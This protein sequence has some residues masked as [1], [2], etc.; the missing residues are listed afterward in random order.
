MRASVKTGAM[1]A[2]FAPSIVG[3]ALAQQPPGAP[4][5]AA[6]APAAPAKPSAPP[7]PDWNT[8]G[9]DQ[10]R[11]A[12]NKGETTLNKD[13]VS[14]LKLL[15]STQTTTPVS[16]VVL[17]TLTTP[18]VSMDVRTPSGR[19][20]L[21]YVLDAFDTLFALDADSGKIVWHKNFP[22]TLKPLRAG[23]WLCPNTTNATPVIDKQRGLVFVLTSDGRLRAVSAGD[24]AERMAATDV[25]APFSRSWSLNL[26]D[27]V[28]YT[29]SGRGCASLLDPKSPISAASTITSGG[30][31]G[32]AA[33]PAEPGSVS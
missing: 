33:T 21:V 8:W 20:N 18:L 4:P 26:I 11:T 32:A 24:G 7:Q 17:A 3:A 23:S 1:G 9:Y 14:K 2:G 28:I 19:K 6:A 31:G 10:E 15:W 13:N 22:N 12:W 30:R 5:A 25:V 16:D 27:D 29:T